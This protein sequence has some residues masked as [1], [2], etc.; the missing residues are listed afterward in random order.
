MKKIF[1]VSAALLLLL[2]LPGLAPAQT[3]TTVTATVLDPNGI[4][5]ANG[6]V[7]FTLVNA[8]G[9]ASF[10]STPQIGGS[11]IAGFVGPVGLSAA[12][13]LSVNLP[14]NSAGGGCIVITPAGTQW[15]PT[16]CASPAQLPIGTGQG[17]FTTAGITITGASQDI[18]ATL[19]ASALNLAQKVN[20]ARVYN[21]LP[22][23][24]TSSIT[25]TTMA[26]AG[27]IPAAGTSYRFSAVASVTV[28]GT[29]CTANSTVVVNAI[30]QDPNEAAPATTANFT[31]T[32]V[33]NGSVGRLIPAVTNPLPAIRAK[34]G[35][36]VQFSTTF[37]AGANCAPAPTVQVAPILEQ[38]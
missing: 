19:N 8:S 36:V 34:A 20:L 22:A 18:S 31:F 25:A 28:V 17:C 23:A 12:G 32:V 33:N 35:T 21:T 13:V 16:V 15:I 26:T 27:T 38:M 14:C 5:Y 30:W 9:S 24:G 29:A 2:A 6:T 11:N 4:A 1:F 7:T 37:T 3:L 10:A